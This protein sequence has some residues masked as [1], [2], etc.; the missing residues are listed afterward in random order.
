MTQPT[1]IY[2]INLCILK[3]SKSRTYQIPSL[4]AAQSATQADD[5][6]PAVCLPR[7]SPLSLAHASPT[8][9]SE[10]EPNLKNSTIKA[11]SNQSGNQ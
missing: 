8:M 5:F 4:V 11:T 1:M 10:L 2:N 3:P 7:E 6:I 9:I